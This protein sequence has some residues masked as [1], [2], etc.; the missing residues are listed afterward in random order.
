MSDHCNILGETETLT[1]AETGK[2]KSIAELAGPAKIEPEAS[3]KFC[4]SDDMSFGG[5]CHICATDH[6]A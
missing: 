3:C 2:T 1:N 4:G 5:L 6:Y